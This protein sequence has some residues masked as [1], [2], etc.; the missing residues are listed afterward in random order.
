M[1]RIKNWTILLKI[2]H[3]KLNYETNVVGK[4]NNWNWTAK[5][6]LNY[7]MENWTMENLQSLNACGRI[8]S[9]HERTTAPLA[10]NNHAL[11]GTKQQHTTE[12]QYNILCNT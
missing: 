3:G 11:N 10:R 1:K 12:K 8:E 5:K 9:C 4:L 6:K 2:E 7:R